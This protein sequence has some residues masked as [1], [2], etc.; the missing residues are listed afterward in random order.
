M[1]LNPTE[2]LARTLY[3]EAGHCSVRGIEALA[4][5]RRLPGRRFSGQ[6]NVAWSRAR[7]AGIDG[8]PRPGSFDSP[9]VANALGTYTLNFVVTAHF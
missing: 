4:S 9:V 6:A 7:H 8:V 2:I 1:S 3:A 5:R